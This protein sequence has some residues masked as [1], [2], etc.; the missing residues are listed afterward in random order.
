[1]TCPQLP[2][3]VPPLVPPLA[4][5]ERADVIICGDFNSVSQDS[6][7]WLL[8]R[9]RLERNHTDACCP[10]VD[11][12]P[13]WLCGCRGMNSLASRRPGWRGRTENGGEGHGWSALLQTSVAS[14]CHPF[15]PPETFPPALS[16][17][18]PPIPAAPQVPVTKETIAHPFALHEAYEAAG[19]RPPFTRKVPGSAAVL[20][21]LWCSRHMRVEAVMKPL[22]QELKPLVEKASLPNRVHPSDHL[23]VGAV[24]RLS[25]P[26][27]A[28]AAADAAAAGHLVV[29]AGT[30]RAASLLDAASGSSGA[31]SP[32]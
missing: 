23:P 29:S 22:Q 26:E 13:C 31:G 15:S 24:L 30:A 19:F 9:G 11:E 1:M 28:G 5:A 25:G 2:L 17:P 21:F 20:D 10:Q 7:C 32:H 12:W 8:R 18:P 3:F 4:A 6:P 27:A 16:P 14:A